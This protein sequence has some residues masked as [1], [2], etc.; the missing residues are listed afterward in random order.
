[1]KRIGLV[2][3]SALFGLTAVGEGF[4]NDLELT[5]LKRNGSNVELT[6]FK[7]GQTRYVEGKHLAVQAAVLTD[8]DGIATLSAIQYHWIL[9]P[10]N[11]LYDA[12]TGTAAYYLQKML[13]PATGGLAA[14]KPVDKLLG[15]VADAVAARG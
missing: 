7:E 12:D 3:F 9:G 15:N 6:F 13:R 1:M 4:F 11:D 5:N 8:D 10:V 2:I 14:F